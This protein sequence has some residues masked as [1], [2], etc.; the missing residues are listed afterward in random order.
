ALR[1]AFASQNPNPVLKIWAGLRASVMAFFRHSFA[2]VLQA[3]LSPGGGKRD[4][5]A[6]ALEPQ[7][8][9]LDGQGLS[10]PSAALGAVG[11]VRAPISA[12]LSRKVSRM[13]G[14]VV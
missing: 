11:K 5:K 13:L 8:P 9:R 6:G 12:F 7:F 2:G 1:S 4:R 14:I 10:R 3:A